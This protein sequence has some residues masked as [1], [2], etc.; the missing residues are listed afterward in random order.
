MS[1]RL[2][3]L[4]DNDDDNNSNNNKVSASF[5]LLR[6]AESIQVEIFESGDRH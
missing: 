1:V 4:N 6:A 2:V 3:G 5:H